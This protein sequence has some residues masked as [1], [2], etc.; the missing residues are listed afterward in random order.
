[1]PQLARNKPLITFFPFSRRWRRVGIAAVA[2]AA[3]LGTAGCSTIRVT[4]TTETAD[5]QMLLTQAAAEA[6]AHLSVANLRDRSV[7]VD[8]HF[9]ARTYKASPQQLFLIADIRAKLLTEGVR[10]MRHRSK[11]DIILEVRS[12]VLAVNYSEL[13]IGIPSIT[14]PGVATSGIPVA[15]PE[16]ALLKNTKQ[17]GFASVAY[18]AYWRKT[19]QIVATSGPFLGR[20]NRNDWWFLGIGPSTSGNIPSAEAK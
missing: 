2:C 5:E 4:N 6:V 20:T 17:H 12:G 8:Y 18:V 14:L 7:Y 3:L 10:L 16:L 19:G 15:T 13:L 11:A 9:L 1:M